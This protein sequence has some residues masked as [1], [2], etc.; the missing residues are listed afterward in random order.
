MWRGL[1]EVL[2]LYPFSE[3]RVQASARDV[4]SLEAS[5]HEALPTVE[6]GDFCEACCD[7]ALG[8]VFDS[9]F[10]DYLCATECVGAN[11][12]SF[13]EVVFGKVGVTGAVIDE[14][15]GYPFP[16]LFLGLDA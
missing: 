16:S 1:A 6:K 10:K 11:H 14:S 3:S 7:E 15:L 9:N 8:S 12:H 2:F 13:E 4:F 5:L